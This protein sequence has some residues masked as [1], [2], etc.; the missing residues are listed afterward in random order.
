MD[1]LIG[2]WDKSWNVFFALQENLL[3]EIDV[4]LS[5]LSKDETIFPNRKN[6]FKAFQFT[7]PE[8]ISVVILGQD[9]YHGEDE[10]MGLSFSVPQNIKIPPSLK[11]IFKEL[12]NDLGVKIPLHGDLTNWAK[13][14]ILLLNSILTVTRN[15][16]A[17]HSKIGWEYFTDKVIAYL[18]KT[19]APKVFVLWGNFAQRKKNLIDEN[20]H[21]II[22]NPH[23]SPLSANKGFLG[24][25]PFS[26]IND[27][28]KKT[29]QKEINWSLL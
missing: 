8:N 7:N 2:N 1:F 13:Q 23:P 9:P 4:K 27:F 14:N 26:Q 19:G 28:L 25:R 21:K 3:K 6:I 18:V 5:I 10:A 29:N 24:S 15:S 22:Q 12:S 16:P 17:S 20:R 11:N